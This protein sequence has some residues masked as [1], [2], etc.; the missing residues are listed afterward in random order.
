MGPRK[1]AAMARFPIP[2][3]SSLFRQYFL[4]LF[5]AVAVPLL[6]AGG[7]QAWFGYRDQRARLDDLLGAEARTAAARIAHFIEQIGDQLAWMVQLSWTEA[8]DERRRIDGL[9]LLRQV[10]AVTSLRLID[11]A[12][13]ERLSVSRTGLNRVESHAD[14]SADPP[15]LGARTKRAWFSPVTFHRNSEPYMTM[16]LA[17]NR[18]AAGVAVAE[19]NL[20]LILD[21][22]AGIRVGETGRA[23]V[24]DGPGRLIAHPDISLVLRGSEDRTGENLQVLRAAIVAQGGGAVTGLDLAGRTVVAAMASI[25]GPDWS[26]IVHQPVAEAFAPIYAAFW[27]LLGLLLAGTGFAAALAYWLANRMTGPIRLLEEGAAS[28]GAGRFDHRIEIARE[29]ELG[30]LAAS[31]NQMAREVA[32]SQERSE[33]INRL[34]RFLAP[35]IAELVDRAGDDSVLDGHRVEVVVVFGDLR[36]FTPF[37]ARSEPAAIMS[38][39][40]EYHAAIGAIVNRHNATLL[41]LAGDGVMILVNAPLACPEPALRAARMVIEMQATVQ[42]LAATWRARG[43]ALGFGIGLA[44]GPATVGRIGSDSRL[45]YTAIGTVTNLASRL[46][47]SAQ[48]GQ[49]LVDRTAAEAIG[50]GVPLL[51]LGTRH[52]KGFD[53]P[54]TVFVVATG[55]DADARSAPDEAPCTT[56]G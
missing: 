53:D 22:I 19:I 40:G 28:I 38:V 37:S 43:H 46:C 5:A 3:R 49:I 2:L 17:G 31:F 7:S 52:L 55:R 9:R 33:R 54:I 42:T 24:L 6:A 20:K 25:P 48:D 14:A 34:K 12:S 47:A 13:R 44:M 35:Q 26:V 4:A 51:S 39:L 27:R 1:D 30:R 41:S 15:V 36:G 18:I 11:G 29:D 56:L 45:D 16:A 8:A 50:S 32:V 21:V 23:F 10:P